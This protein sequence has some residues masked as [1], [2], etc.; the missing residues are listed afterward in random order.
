MIKRIILA[1]Y[2][3]LFINLAYAQNFNNGI[4]QG[5]VINSKNNEPVPFANII[6]YNT[7]KGL[8]T[9][10]DGEF[11]LKEIKP[12]FIKLKV[13]AVGFETYVSPEIMVTNARKVNFDIPLN[14]TSF[15]IEEVVVK[16][17]VFR[18]TE[19]SPLSMRVIGI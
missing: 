10:F 1:L 15:S 14:E 3:T 4:V 18:K 8:A 6:I 13:S 16:P 7:N 9:N 11:I 12:G 17:S 19:E 2:I 5:Q